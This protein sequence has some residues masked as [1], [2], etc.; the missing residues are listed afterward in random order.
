MSTN[1]ENTRISWIDNDVIYEQAWFAEVVEKLPLLAGISGRINL[2]VQSAKVETIRVC[3]IYNE[4]THISSWGS[5]R[6]SLLSRE[7]DLRANYQPLPAE[8]LQSR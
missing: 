6:P 1:I 8:L 7:Q 2:T 4:T 5:G 3:G